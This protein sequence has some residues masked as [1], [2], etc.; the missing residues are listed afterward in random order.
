MAAGPIYLGAVGE[1][2]MVRAF[3]AAAFVLA[4]ALACAAE[5]PAGAA[6]CSGCHAVRSGVQSP[7]PTLN[8]RNAAEITAAMAEFR[9]GGRPA[10][11]MDRIAKG[12]SAEEVQAIA[13]WLQSL[14]LPN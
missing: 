5:E 4:P 1:M 3:I 6:S 10:T 11:V 12:Y 14:P 8:G 9:T 13:A 2:K 7:I